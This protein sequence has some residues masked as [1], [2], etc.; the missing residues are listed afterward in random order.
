MRDVAGSP[1]AD[2]WQR[3]LCA[4]RLRE[5]K[6]DHAATPVRLETN[7]SALK[8]KGI[9]LGVLG[10]MMFVCIVMFRLAMLM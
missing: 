9:P 8:D 10:S 1:T 6:S 5:L 4:A 2:P 7:E 3:L